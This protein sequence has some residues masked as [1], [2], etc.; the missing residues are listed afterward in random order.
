MMRKDISAK[1]LAMA[2]SISMP[3]GLCMPA[4]PA[5]AA[6]ESSV[7][8]E[9]VNREDGVSVKSMPGTETAE[10]TAGNPEEVPDMA[11]EEI[12]ED[13][14]EAEKCEP[15]DEKAGSGVNEAA[16]ETANEQQDA[17]KSGQFV[18][19]NIPY[20]D[21]YKAEI[22]NDVQV[23]AFTSATLNKTRTGGNTSD[24][25]AA[26]SYHVNADGTDI[27]GVTYVVIAQ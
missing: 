9:G 22:N 12:A 27:T 25:L 7:V 11:R 20:D 1:F 15:E 8:Q 18:L 24:G 23:D 3:A 10:V 13:G 17:V 19:M 6:E 2:L 14:T 4:V 16:E 21:F 26:G 5:F